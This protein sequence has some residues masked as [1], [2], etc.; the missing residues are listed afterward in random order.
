MLESCPKT[1]FC[2][3]F[4][5]QSIGTVDADAGVGDVN[6]DTIDVLQEIDGAGDQVIVLL[7]LDGPC[8]HPSPYHTRNH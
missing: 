4:D 2:Q 7:C 5:T 1:I 8:K 3:Q 6:A